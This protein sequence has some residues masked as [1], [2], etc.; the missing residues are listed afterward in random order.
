MADR[1]ADPGPSALREL[2]A[3]WRSWSDLRLSEVRSAPAVDSERLVL[4]PTVVE[5]GGTGRNRSPTD[6]S[7]AP[8]ATGKQGCMEIN[9]LLGNTRQGLLPQQESEQTFAKGNHS[10][11]TIRI[12]RRPSPQKAVSR[13]PENI[14]DLQRLSQGEPFRGYDKNSEKTFSAKAVSRLPENI[15]DL[16]RPSQGKPFRGHDKN[17]AKTF[18]AKS[19]STVTRKHQESGKTFA[20]GTLPRLRQEF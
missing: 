10:T 3:C 12:L 1:D 7:L 8:A 15:R 11:V 5:S 19:R 9:L 4:V 13:L 17:S 2:R 18:S 16:K 6:D 14:R 20:G